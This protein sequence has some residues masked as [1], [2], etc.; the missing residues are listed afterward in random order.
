MSGADDMAG[1]IRGDS[2][3]EEYQGSLTLPG[4]TEP[5]DISLLLD[6]ER[7]AVSVRFDTEVAG[8]SEWEGASVS[9]VRR[10]K[11][12]EVWFDTI[13]IPKETVELRWKCNADLRDGT[14]AGVVVARPNELRISGEK[15]FTLSKLA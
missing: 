14:L 12:I 15:G 6:K 1:T 7:K 3:R 5:R 2:N 10:L 13:G 11:Y 9:V 4:E 8:A